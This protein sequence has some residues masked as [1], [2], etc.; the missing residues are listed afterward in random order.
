MPFITDG[1]F[2]LSESNA[3]LKYLCTKHSSKIP[4]H[5]WPK[6]QK[7]RAHI[8]QFLEY[9][10]NSFRP[11]LIAPF[12]FRVDHVVRGKPFDE[13]AWTNSIPVV[14]EE[15]DIFQEMLDQYKGSFLV[16]DAPSIA[17]L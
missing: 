8:E 7:Q 1:D 16:S 6:D 17:D 14:Y 15:L 2:N 4:S 3:I 5:Y 11:S 13:E 12:E 9:W 10:Q